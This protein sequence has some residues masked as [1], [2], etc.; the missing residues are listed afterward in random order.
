LTKKSYLQDCWNVCL[1]IQS[2]VGDQ[3]DEGCCVRHSLC[4]RILAD[5]HEVYKRPGTAAESSRSAHTAPPATTTRT[6][7]GHIFIGSMEPSSNQWHHIITTEARS[8]N[9]VASA[10]IGCWTQFTFNMSLTKVLELWL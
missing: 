9:E 7:H 8:R 2:V 5:R 10:N 6:T 3:C 4:R 1:L